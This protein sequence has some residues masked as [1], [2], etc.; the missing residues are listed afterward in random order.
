MIEITKDLPF[1]E[2]NS[3]D[4][5]EPVM[6][7]EKLF[8]EY[9]VVLHSVTIRCNNRIICRNIRAMLKEAKSDAAE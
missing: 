6:N 7:E 4:F 9:S 1:E 5:F 8:A 2:C 3:C